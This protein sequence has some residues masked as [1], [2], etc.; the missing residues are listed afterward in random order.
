MDCTGFRDE[1][2][3]SE[4]P[5]PPLAVVLAIHLVDLEVPVFSRISVFGL[6]WPQLPRGQRPAVA[7]CLPDPSGS[8]LGAW[9]LGQECSA[10]GPIFL[11]CFLKY[12]RVPMKTHRHHPVAWVGRWPRVVTIFVPSGVAQSHP[13]CILIRSCCVTSESGQAP[14]E[15]VPVGGCDP[16]SPAA[17]LYRVALFLLWQPQPWLTD[18][19]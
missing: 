6:L 14:W 1:A 19:P 11:G 3:A 13:L 17:R 2:A 12:P 9:L 18:E 8:Q 7:Q 15:L 10:P 16:A 5:L 4:T